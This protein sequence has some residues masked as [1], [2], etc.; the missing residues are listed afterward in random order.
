MDPFAASHG[1]PFALRQ[2]TVKI[3][4]KPDP[5]LTLISF[6]SGAN[7]HFPNHF[8][9][10]I[11]PS[12]LKFKREVEILTTHFWRYYEKFSFPDFGNHDVFERFFFLGRTK[13]YLP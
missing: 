9:T 11:S 7:R 5:S 3:K 12:C 10:T 8:D 1:L 2:S 6:S 13:I 4:H